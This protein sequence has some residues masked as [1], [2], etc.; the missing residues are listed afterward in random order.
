[1]HLYIC[2]EYKKG[3]F[4]SSA[5]SVSPLASPAISRTAEDADGTR[6]AGRRA[7][8]RGLR[9]SQGGHPDMRHETYDSLGHRDTET[10][11]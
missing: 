10:A 6:G 2:V 9:A 5:P 7:A 11:S 1:M 3:A 4:I 8:P